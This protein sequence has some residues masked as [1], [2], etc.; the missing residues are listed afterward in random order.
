MEDRRV[1]RLAKEDVS[2]SRME[3]SLT[4]YLKGSVSSGLCHWPPE[5]VPVAET[6]YD[7]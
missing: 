7:V 3:Y 6:L 1:Q 2:W 5:Y 4:A